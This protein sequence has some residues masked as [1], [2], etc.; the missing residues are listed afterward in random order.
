MP[1]DILHANATNATRDMCP[2]KDGAL[3]W[4]HNGV[5]NPRSLQLLFCPL[6]PEEYLPEHQD[7]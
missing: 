2:I 5:V 7:T 1:L 4:S 6:L 3:A